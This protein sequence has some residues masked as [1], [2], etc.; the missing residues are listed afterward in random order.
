MN[1]EKLT[2]A[3]HAIRM[4]E[5]QKEALIDRLEQPLIPEIKKPRARYGRAVAA[6]AACFALALV[7]FG[8]WSMQ[9][10]PDKPSLS[11]PAA[12]TNVSAVPNGQTGKNVPAVRQPER[13]QPADATEAEAPSGQVD[14]SLPSVASPNGETVL[15]PDTDPPA[16]VGN[17]WN[18][19]DPE[20]LSNIHWRKLVRGEP[21]MDTGKYPCPLP[22]THAYSIGLGDALREYA[23][24]DDVNY[25]VRIDVFPAD[26]LPDEPQAQQAYYETLSKRLYETMSIDDVSFG[27]DTFEN[28]NTGEAVVTFGAIAYDAAV[29]DAFPDLPDV[30]LFL[31]LYDEISEIK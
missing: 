27:I 7:A 14:A 16:N 1:D 29:F 2:R 11:A 18:I 21:G 23:G 24:R 4:E 15:A 19:T 12:T 26:G 31:S 20:E 5:E 6:L 25:Y 13:E 17:L 22:G 10:K 28:H 30:G 8:L 3:L 9:R